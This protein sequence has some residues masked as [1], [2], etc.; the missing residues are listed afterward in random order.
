MGAIPSATGDAGSAPKKQRNVMTLQENVELDHR[1]DSPLNRD[2]R[3][4]STAVVA[5]ISEDS[6]CKQIIRTYGIRS[7]VL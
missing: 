7:T 6:S 3:L 2:R 1:L 4:R 5:A